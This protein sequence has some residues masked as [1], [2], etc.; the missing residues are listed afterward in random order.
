[1]HWNRCALFSCSS[2]SV[3]PDDRDWSCFGAP[4][5]PCC[6][7]GCCPHLPQSVWGGD[8]WL[9]HSS[10]CQRLS[11]PA[12]GGPPDSTAGRLT[13]G[14]GHC[15]NVCIHLR[16]HLRTLLLQKV[17]HIF[18]IFLKNV[19]Y[20]LEQKHFGCFFVENVAL[21]PFQPGLNHSGLL[22]DVSCIY[23]VWSC[24]PLKTHPCMPTIAVGQACLT[25]SGRGMTGD[26]RQSTTVQ[27]QGMLFSMAKCCRGNTTDISLYVTLAINSIVPEFKTH[28]NELPHILV[29]YC[30][31]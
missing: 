5:G 8:G 20:F 10:G 7:G 16:G 17:M 21:V 24:G 13:Q 15:Y 22:Y 6:P 19:H 4:L 28:S 23:S 18:W 11:G 25:Y 29:V 30:Y 31:F 26:Q 9:L 2:G 1:M 12:L 3:Q 14:E 27:L